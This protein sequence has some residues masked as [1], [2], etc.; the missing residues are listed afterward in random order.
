MDGQTHT[1]THTQ[2]G[3]QTDKQTDRRRQTDGQSDIQT[4]IQTDRQYLSHVTSNTKY[5]YVV[6][7]RVINQLSAYTST[8]ITLTPDR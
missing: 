1:H 7:L 2:I 8:C 5:P 4:N 6:S 3:R